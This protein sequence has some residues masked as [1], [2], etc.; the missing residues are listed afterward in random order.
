MAGT[1]PRWKR[2]DQRRSYNSRQG[3][4]RIDFQIPIFSRAVKVNDH[5]F[6]R[7]AELFDRDVGAVSP[8]AAVVGIEGDLG[9][10]AF[11]RL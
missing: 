9:R 7:K 4:H 6:V 10:E 11:G 5:F 2:S 1:S 3:A 8:R